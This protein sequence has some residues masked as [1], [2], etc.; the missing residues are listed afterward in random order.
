MYQAEKDES[1][2]EHYILLINTIN[3]IMKMMGI[4]FK[5]LPPPGASSGSERGWKKSED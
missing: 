3:N 5:F 4:A 2:Q 1:P